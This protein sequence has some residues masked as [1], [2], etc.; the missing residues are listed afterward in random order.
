MVWF[1]LVWCGLCC[2]VLCCVVLCCVVLCCVV[3][4]CGGLAWFGWVQELSA[5]RP[6]A[7]EAANRLGDARG[8]LEEDEARLQQQLAD[9][10]AAAK[11]RERDLTIRIK[12]QRETLKATREEADEL[13]NI[14]MV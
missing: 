8:K 1:G 2:V 9:A 6:S 4:C 7:Q 5:L 10:E 14:A 12:Q 11:R 3:L 13:A